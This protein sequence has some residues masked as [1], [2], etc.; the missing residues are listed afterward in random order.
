MRWLLTIP[1]LLLHISLLGQSPCAPI[2]EQEIAFF[3]NKLDS[4]PQLLETEGVIK[5][6]DECTL[7]NHLQYYFPGQ[8]YTLCPEALGIRGKARRAYICMLAFMKRGND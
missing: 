6:K 2:T 5:N 7:K 3:S 8:E 1:V 4:L